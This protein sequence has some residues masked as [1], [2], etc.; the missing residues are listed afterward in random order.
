MPLCE[1]TAVGVVNALLR[2]RKN[3]LLGE[4]KLL[5]R[6]FGKLVPTVGRIFFEMRAVERSH[7][8]LIIVRMKVVRAGYAKMH[9]LG[10]CPSI[11]ILV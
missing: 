11:A 1:P 2:D 6:S 3:A 5:D 8:S 10:C 7:A 4:E 9:S